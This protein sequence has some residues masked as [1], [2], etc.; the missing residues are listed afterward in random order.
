MAAPLVGRP[1]DGLVMSLT[2]STVLAWGSGLLVGDCNG[3]RATPIK[4]CTMYTCISYPTVHVRVH[5]SSYTMHNMDRRGACTHS[6]PCTVHARHT[7]HMQLIL[8]V[9]GG[10]DEEGGAT[11]GGALLRGMSL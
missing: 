11:L 8:G 5:Q 10:G 7:P 2:V 6:I 4:A 1:D 3:T 9:G